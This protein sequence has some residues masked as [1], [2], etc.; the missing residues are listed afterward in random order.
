MSS[1]EAGSCIGSCSSSVSVLWGGAV[2][3]LPMRGAFLLAGLLGSRTPL[4]PSAHWTL[5]IPAVVPS[6]VDE[7]EAEETMEALL[8]RVWGGWVVMAS[9]WC[10]VDWGGERASLEVV[11]REEE[12]VC[13]EWTDNLAR[14]GSGSVGLMRTEKSREWCVSKE[15]WD[16]F[17]GRTVEGRAEEAGEREE[18]VEESVHVGLS[19]SLGGEGVVPCCCVVGS[20]GGCVA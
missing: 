15:P 6:A 20:E 9:E 10:E 13:R 1:E 18:V 19:E 3:K 5:S 12:E 8:T 14:F 7:E 2:S 4:L 11:G 16:G 17:A